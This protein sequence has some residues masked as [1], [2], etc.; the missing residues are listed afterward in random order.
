M[1][2]ITIKNRITQELTNQA[3]FETVELTDSWMSAHEMK[4]EKGNAWGRY[5]SARELPKKGLNY[6]GEVDYNDALLVNDGEFIKEFDHK[7]PEMW[8]LLHAE[9]EVVIEDI[10]A[11][12]EASELRRSTIATG[13]LYKNR[14]EDALNYIAGCNVNRSL[15]EAQIDSMEVTFEEVVV[16]LMKGRPDKAYGLIA[17]ITPDGTIVTDEIKAE[18]LAILAGN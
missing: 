14:C 8:V 12:H 2:K 9:Y 5:Y 4:G 18:M 1:F 13:K 6:E 15:T 7:D 16:K 17:N 10:T 3:S 11:E